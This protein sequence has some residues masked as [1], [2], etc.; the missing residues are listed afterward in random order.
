MPGSLQ[1][2]VP[3]WVT[4][5]D[6]GRDGRGDACHAARKRTP[7]G[8]LCP[9]IRR[10]QARGGGSCSAHRPFWK[11]ETQRACL[12]CCGAPQLA[13][14][15]RVV[16]AGQM[17]SHTPVHALPGTYGHGR[18][19]CARRARPGHTARSASRPAVSVL[20]RL[21][22]DRSLR[23]RDRAW[24]RGSERS[25]GHRHRPCLSSSTREVRIHLPSHR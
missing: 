1:L 23:H 11:S 7:A 14:G 25:P 17:R 19:A 15:R 22:R 2:L 13:V 20:Q 5:G 18:G 8:G 4:V 21:H 12:P 3:A 10:G 16:T 9:V 6:G 24:P